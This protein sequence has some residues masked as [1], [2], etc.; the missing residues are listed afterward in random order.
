MTSQATAGHELRQR[1]DLRVLAWPAFDGLPVDAL[2]TTRHGGVSG[3]DYATLNLSFSVGDRPE[4]VLENR[5]RAAAALGASLA[6]F[7][8]ATQ[9]HG[10][11]P[12]W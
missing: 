1:G 5:R 2:V 4:N 7:V 9:V 11:G 8:F 10:P 12:P 3:G 6:D